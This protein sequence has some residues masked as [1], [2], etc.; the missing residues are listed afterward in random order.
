MATA[1]HLQRHH[2]DPHSVS[3]YI[4]N[5]SQHTQGAGRGFSHLAKSRSNK[6]HN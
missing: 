1:G 3:N 6:A 5:N 4:L 2:T